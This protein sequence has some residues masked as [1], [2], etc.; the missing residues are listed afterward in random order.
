MWAVKAG[1]LHGASEGHRE[2][3]DACPW[4]IRSAVS[5]SGFGSGFIILLIFFKDLY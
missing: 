1:Q 4:E 2:H 5:N 3:G